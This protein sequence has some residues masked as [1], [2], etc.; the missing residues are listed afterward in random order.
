MWLFWMLTSMK[1]LVIGEND[2]EMFRPDVR[3]MSEGSFWIKSIAILP[4]GAR[5]KTKR[6][7]WEQ[8]MMLDEDVPARP[9]LVGK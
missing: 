8:E 3:E 2:Y 1:K 6:E 5:T 9:D 7:K 4:L